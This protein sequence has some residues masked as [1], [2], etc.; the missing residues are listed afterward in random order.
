MYDDPV[1]DDLELDIMNQMQLVMTVAF[2]L[3]IDEKPLQEFLDWS[4]TSIP[5]IAPVLLENFPPE[6][7]PKA[8]YWVGVNLW[9]SAPKPGN[10][11]K[12][13]ALPKPGRNER[14]PCG[15]GKKHKQCCAH[16]LEFK[17]INED[18][19]WMLFPEVVSKAQINRLVKNHQLPL[20]G[21]AII[22]SLFSDEGDDAQVIKLLEPLFEGNASRLNHNQSGLLD[23]LCDSYNEHYKTD[24]KKKDLLLRMC[25]HPDCS[26]RAEAWQ[27]MS[28]WQLDL[29][30]L[31]AAMQAL[32]KAM[33][34][35]PDNPS[36]SLLELTLLVSSKQIEQ[37]KQRAIFWRR[38][39]KHL[40]LELPELI[41]TLD[42]AQTDPAGA[43]Q[44][45]LS[46]ADDDPRLML[47]LEWIDKYKDLPIK[48]Y[49]LDKI[50]LDEDDSE[51]NSPYPD[52]MLDAA[53]LQP[54]EGIFKLEMQWEGL[55]PIE[56][57]FGTQ[58]EPM[59]GVDIWENFFDTDWL[60]FLQQNPESINSLSI[61]D[62]LVTLIYIHPNNDSI[63][64]PL[65][66]IQ[67]LLERCDNILQQLDFSTEQNIPWVI[68]ENRP[69]LRLL[70]HDI[71]LA[72]NQTEQAHAIKQI[73]LYL[74]I[75][76][77]DNHGY[78]SLLTNHYLQNDDDIEAI[79]LIANYP[80]D[81][82][83]ETRYGLVLALYKLGDLQAASLA[84]QAAI[85]AMPLVAEYLIK[86]RVTQPK[87]SEYG[88]SYGGK[89][90]AWFYREEMRETWKQTKGCIEWLKK[91][92]KNQ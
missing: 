50:E 38:K 10:H 4:Q 65:G 41:N 63:W 24:K 23:I 35:E 60:D 68:P 18:A 11:F 87:L 36:H 84:L 20:Q 89:D 21:V 3:I 88:I 66:K 26:I 37:A 70:T 34:A 29:G 1:E 16:L 43:L 75:N 42:K 55:K 78:R 91:Q 27:R 92:L 40:E 69:A 47:L 74:Q 14:C 62:D 28:S 71:N 25:E 39:L 72:I 80:D 13:Q 2:G 51:D 7:R 46:N 44:I 90:Q 85:I 15:S 67:P 5:I 73:K 82:L 64:G 58:L 81:M 76:P 6:E 56:K 54:H 33:Q 12:P 59:D 57:P 30:D 83:A 22:A 17:P 49:T 79:E 86:P 31:P 52:P 61:I 77:H 8:A 48:K 9:N 53:T 32:T 19:F 45:S